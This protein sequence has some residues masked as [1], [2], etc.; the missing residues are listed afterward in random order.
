MESKVRLVL[1]GLLLLAIGLGIG[2]YLSPDKVREVEKVVEKI[3]VVKEKDETI[4]KKY[5]PNTGKLIEEKKETKEKETNTESSKKEKEVEKTKEQ[6]HYAVKGG[7]AIDPRDSGK[8]IPRA[9]VE[10]R[11]P[12]FNSWIGAEIDVNIDKPLTGI[13][14]RMEF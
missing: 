7:A 10:L 1:V 6:K 14:L 3:K 11:L 13:Y 5:D 2:Y 9:G 12:F 8:V 4:T